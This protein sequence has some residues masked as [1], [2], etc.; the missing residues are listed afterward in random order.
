M[1]CANCRSDN[2][3]IRSGSN[4]NV[5]VCLD[6]WWGVELDAE[7]Q[8]LAED[9]VKI[10]MAQ[11]ATGAGE[12]MMAKMVIVQNCSL[13]GYCRHDDA[14][15]WCV[16]SPDEP[17]PCPALGVRGDCPHADAPEWVAVSSGELPE[18]PG[19]Y[20]VAVLAMGIRYRA[21]RGWSPSLATW[22]EIAGTTITHWLRGMPPLP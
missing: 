5:W 21:I 3:M 13:C 10:G 19:Q 15:H 14:R 1:I 9:V 18:A 12:G 2:P 6:C 8:L 17:M 11:H 16:A 4:P 22:Q 20:D 7:G